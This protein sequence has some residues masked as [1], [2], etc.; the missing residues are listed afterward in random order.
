MFEFKLVL[1]NPH[2][3]AKLFNRSAK[4]N[5]RV[6]VMGPQSST[7][8]QVFAEVVVKLPKNNFTGL[9]R[10][11]VNQAVALISRKLNV[12][13]KCAN[14]TLNKRHCY[15][16]VFTVWSSRNIARVCLGRKSL[17]FEQRQK[18]NENGLEKM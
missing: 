11:Y 18:E 3:Q 5:A 8:L 7:W 9:S 17:R 16:T 15:S 12:N 2:K 13:V 1:S 14:R 10:H 6:F 4:S